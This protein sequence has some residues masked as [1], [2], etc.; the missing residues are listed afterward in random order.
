MT[1]TWRDFRLPIW[2]TMLAVAIA[3]VVSPWQFSFVV[4]GAALGTAAGVLRR[5]RALARRRD[6]ADGGGR[7]GSPRAG[8]SRRR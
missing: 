4:F 3:L 2:L 8:Q 1:G 5:R 6:A 7:G